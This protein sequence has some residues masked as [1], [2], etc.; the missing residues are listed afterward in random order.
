MRF[1][2]SQTQSTLDRI[3]KMS[4]QAE[5]SHQ[6]EYGTEIEGHHANSTAGIMEAISALA[7]DVSK[8][9]SSISERLETLESRNEG[10]EIPNE[11]ARPPTAAAIPI[12]RG[13]TNMSTPHSTPRGDD[14]GSNDHRSWADRSLNER[15]D[16]EAPLPWDEEDEEEAGVK[17]I[18]VSENTKKFLQDTFT[19]CVSNPTRK[20][21]RE[22]HGV[23]KSAP[24]RVPK[25][26]KVIKDRISSK[27][28][29]TDKDLGRIQAFILDAV[30]PLTAIVE[31]AEKE[32]LT[33]KTAA[34]AARMAL[35][36]IGNASAQLSRDRRKAAIMDMNPKIADLAERDSIYEKAAPSLFGEKFCKEAKEHE[37]QLRC[38]DKASR[39]GS[40][41]FRQASRQRKGGGY[42]P[43]Y[44]NFKGGTSGRFTTRGG[45][46]HPYKNGG[47]YQ[48]FKGKGTFQKKQQQ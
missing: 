48:N 19:R 39:S 41:N 9:F 1:D 36:F 25:L 18:T 26:D 33:S 47:S 2:R 40:Q 16:Y 14:D 20:K 38:L 5:N 31:G 34:E 32:E 37:E 23:P 27:T 15:M 7:D 46:H 28:A 8:K 35:Q 42:S 6:A 44:N 12:P 11:D 43:Q 30:G 17:V 3:V 4:Y 13:H 45:R 29:K 22:R 10:S 24:T 21:W